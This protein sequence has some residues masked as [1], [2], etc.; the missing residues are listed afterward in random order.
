M[1][2]PQKA[3]LVTGVS[4]GIGRAT[5][6]LLAAQGYRV[7]GGLRRPAPGAPLPAPPSGVEPL[8]LD[9]TS[10]EAVAAVAQRLAGDLPTGLDALVNNAG[11]APPA[12]LELANLDEFRRILEVNTVA[13]LRVIQAMLPLLRTARGRIINMSSMNGTV[14]MPIVGAYSASKYAL[15]ALSDTLRVELRPWDIGV[16]VIRPGQVRTEIFT[17]AGAFLD[18]RA[19]EIPDHLAQGY[20]KLYTRASMF[21]RRGSKALTAPEDVARVVFKALSARRMKPRY[22][23]GFDAVGLQ[24]AREWLPTWLLDRWLA[25]AMG[26][27][28]RG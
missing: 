5:A 25:R 15:E 4:T 17:K 24:I 3:A 16:T 8:E 26:L 27:M 22:Y 6:E 14:A 13:P 12:A 2:Q 1:P 9:V 20:A 21:N 10:D 18:E 23:A 19:L 28:V 11:I 7:W